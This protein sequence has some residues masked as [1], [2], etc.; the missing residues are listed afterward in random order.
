MIPE[1]LVEENKKIRIKMSKNYINSKVLFSKD[2]KTA[3]LYSS[4]MQLNNHSQ[5]NYNTE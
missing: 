2:L 3:I 4:G 5:A 1:L